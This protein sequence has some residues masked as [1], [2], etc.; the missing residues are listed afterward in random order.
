M[1]FLYRKSM[2]TNLHHEASRKDASC[3]FREYSVGD[4]GKVIS[5][6][7]VRDNKGDIP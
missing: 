1:F 3:S 5:R 6:Y 2:Q 4:D 7:N